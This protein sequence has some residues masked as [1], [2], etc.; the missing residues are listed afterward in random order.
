VAYT[1]HEASFSFPKLSV[2][3]FGEP[4]V[5]GL[6][7]VW[8]AEQLG[9]DVPPNKAGTGMDFRIRISVHLDRVCNAYWRPRFIHWY[10]CPTRTQRGRALRQS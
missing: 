6:F 5:T 2:Y 3:T 1:K 4:R 10:S 8:H 9:L 7:C